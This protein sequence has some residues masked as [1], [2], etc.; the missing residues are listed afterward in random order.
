MRQTILVTGSTGLIGKELVKTLIEKNHNVVAL[1]H[2][3]TPEQTRGIV[4]VCHDLVAPKQDLKSPMRSAVTVVHLAWD[5][6]AKALENTPANQSD[7]YKMLQNVYTAATDVGVK[8][9][10][11]VSALNASP[12]SVSPFLQEKYAC[13]RLLVNSKKDLTRIIVRTPLLEASE[14][15]QLYKS[16]LTTMQYP[17]FYPIP[18]SKESMA[19]G[20]VQQVVRDICDSLSDSTFK[21]QIKN[22]HSDY[23]TSVQELFKSVALKSSKTGKFAVGGILGEVMYNL[24]QKLQ[25]KKTDNAPSARYFIDIGKEMGGSK[26]DQ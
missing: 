24:A 7:N 18:Q 10:I 21:V 14:N 16:I 5:F 23:K 13:E 8:K 11:F 15:H 20:L 9:I 2:R 3:T 22:V 6:A 1:Y 12:F 17:G 26:I 19:F 4:P 25:F